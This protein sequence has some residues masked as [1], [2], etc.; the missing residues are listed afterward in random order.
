MNALLKGM[1]NATNIA[2]TENNAMAYAT[3]NNSIVDF[4]AQAGAMR[5]RSNVDIINMFNNAFGEDQLITTKLAFYFRDARGGQGE[6]RLFRVILKYL[7]QY[8]PSIVKT[9]I[10]HIVEY[11]RW[12]DL[13]ELFGTPCESIMLDLVKNQFFTD[14]NSE[15]PSLL[16]KW[17]PSANASSQNT[18]ALAH[19]FINAFGFSERSYRKALTELRTKINI[20]ETL[21][22]K[23]N[24]QAIDYSN[25]PSCANLKYMKAF[26]RND[27]ERYRAFVEQAVKGEK[28]V[29]AKVLYPYEIVKSIL[30]QY[31]RNYTTSQIDPSLDLSMDMLWKA[32]PD[33]I[34]DNTDNVLA[35]IDTSGSMTSN[36]CL[37]ISAAIALGIYFAEHNKG[38]FANHFISFASRPQLIKIVG[39]DIAAKSRY[40]FKKSLIDNTNIE[41][42]FDLILKTVQ[43]NNLSQDEIPSRLI[44]I[45]D[46]QFDCAVSRSQRSTHLMK[47][48]KQKWDNAGFQLPKLI[49]WN[50]DAKA[51]TFPMTTDENGVQFVSGMSPSIF[52]S[53]LKDKFVTPFEL[54]LDVVNSERYSRITI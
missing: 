51:E 27:E 48:I 43:R 44:I 20:V 9:N 36:D 14:L 46:M 42:V 38:A 12:D 7:A 15:Y 39:N 22:T 2:Y 11:G 24:Y 45:S 10:S 17:M 4:F 32:L 53:L 47:T 8:K 40:I 6:R 16:G 1:S 37:P 41:G 21:I 19:K 52:T 29:N 31:D 18:I 28:K 54:V 23:K 49:Y 5:S 3:T 13:F 26:W 34:G 35:V 50:V 25:V 33:Y 30:K